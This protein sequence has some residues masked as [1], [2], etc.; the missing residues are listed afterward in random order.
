MPAPSKSVVQPFKGI[1]V[2]NQGEGKTCSL[3]S[4]LTLGYKVYMLDFE[5]GSETLI[6]LI[7]DE[8]HYPYAGY[9]SS[10]NVD[11]TQSSLVPIGQ[12]MNVGTIERVR[13]D[14]S[15]KILKTAKE[16]VLKPINASGFVTTNEMLMN[17]IDED[18]KLGSIY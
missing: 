5:G 3:A 14:P 7:N 15:G 12:Q 2:A 8:E 18:R 17:W 16:M 6:N 1:V 10:H 4:L 9:C 13:K 11:L